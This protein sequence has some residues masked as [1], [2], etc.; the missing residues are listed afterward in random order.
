M[1]RRVLLLV[2]RAKP[3]VV[4]ALPEIR[5]I[6][7]RGGGTIASEQDARLGGLP[8]V[9][10]DARGGSGGG[11]GAEG[12]SGAELIVVLG[13]D[14]TLITQATRCVPLGLPMLGVN[15]GKLG[16]LAEF[17]LDD[18]R[19]QARD[20]FSGHNHLAYQDRALLA[21]S[22]ERAG[23]TPPGAPPAWH[24]A[25]LA[26]NDA[27]ITAGPPFR[28]VSIGLS[29]DGQPGP[30]VLGDGLIVCT[31]LGSTAYNASAGGPIVAP[32]ARTL[33]IT[34]IAAHSLAFRPVVVAGGSG[35]VLTMN[36]AN[37]VDGGGT[38]LLLDGQFA[39]RLSAGDRVHLKLDER[40]VRLVHNPRRGYW[41]T[42][43]QKMRW[44]ESPINR[45]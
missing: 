27:V 44:A 17:D 35:I 24:D 34:P 36:R 37:E 9:L 42:L 2:N 40:T 10:P 39:G 16:F 45:G 20:L 12:S 21:V 22:V 43:I 3:E 29:I 4:E 38:S 7:Q 25:A 19:A 33:T 8:P 23:V 15:L 14:G 11:A 31:P 28:M 18:L 30:T 5:A 26:L 41:S 13:G 6:I 32:D 1:P